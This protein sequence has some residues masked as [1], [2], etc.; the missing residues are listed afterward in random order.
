MPE[1]DLDDD[2]YEF[3]DKFSSKESNL[4]ASGYVKDSKVIL[5]TG[6]WQDLYD[7][8]FFGLPENSTLILDPE[9]AVLLAERGRIKLF[10]NSDL[11]EEIPIHEYVNYISAIQKEFWRKYVVYK[12]LRGRGYVVRAGYGELAPYRRYPRGAKPNKAQSDTFIFP[13]AEGAYLDLGQLDTIVKQA[14]AN[15]KV[16]ILGMVDR[17]GD[18][19]YYKASEFSIPINTEKFEIPEEILDKKVPEKTKRI[20]FNKD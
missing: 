19:T 2:D 17:S 15:R 6:Q 11:V 1:N 9:E 10:K 12:D 7:N 8:N 3:D 4:L 16:L 5:T 20:D 14:Q 18:V 13:F